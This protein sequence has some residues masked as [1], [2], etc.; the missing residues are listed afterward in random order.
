MPLN[1]LKMVKMVHLTLYVCMCV[2]TYTYTHFTIGSDVK[3]QNLW[4]EHNMVPAPQCRY[5]ISEGSY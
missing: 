1:V 3:K 2:Y 4:T 5:E